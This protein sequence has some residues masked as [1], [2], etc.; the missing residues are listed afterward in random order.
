MLL[1][2]VLRAYTRHHYEILRFCHLNR[3]ISLY[4]PMLKIK[5][6]TSNLRVSHRPLAIDAMYEEDFTMLEI[7]LGLPDTPN[8]FLSVVYEYD[9]GQAKDKESVM[10]LACRRHMDG[11]KRLLRRILTMDIQSK[12]LTSITLSGLGLRRIPVDIFHVNLLS[13]DIRE[14]NLNEYPCAHLTDQNYLGWNCPM[15]E[16]LN[17]SNN[18]FTYIH[19]DIFSLP[20]LF[21]LLMNGNVIQEVPAQMWTAPHLNTL[22]LSNN[23]ILD[24]PCPP[25]VHRTCSGNPFLFGYRTMSLHRRRNEAMVDGGEVCLQSLRKSSINYNSRSIHRVSV[26][27]VLHMLDLSGNHL[28]SVPRGLAC[29]APLLRTLKLSKNRITSM[30]TVYDYPS[31]LQSLDLSDNGLTRGVDPP[32]II[33]ASNTGNCI[34]S[35]LVT[36]QHPSCL[37]QQ[38]VN[39]SCLKYL[40]LGNN[41][42]A[43]L[44]LEYE[45]EANS[46]HSDTYSE[47]D[48][49]KNASVS[50]QLVLFFPNLQGLRI[51]NNSLTRIPENIHKLTKL[52][53]L[54]VSHN[55]LISALPP[56]LHRL[57]SL[58]VFRHEGIADPIVQELAHFK[59]TAE[60][61]YYLKARGMR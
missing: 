15:L 44:V 17:F 40:Y 3:F 27:F 41:S 6:N 14:N 39:F 5:S 46:E 43:D 11:S 20:S 45:S 48:L 58:F 13:L 21:R 38:H 7:I 2:S 34:Q 25:R 8:N 29:L 30:G 9:H 35:Q 26:N 52:R 33:T 55:E 1:V 12:F 53:E 42:I 61:L 19:P 56:L 24:L 49:L 23:L 47:F 4:S 36:K 16:T 18:F 32:P 60:I 31:F 10:S 37:H 22:E 50:S 28:T 51:S 57:T 54:V 59:N